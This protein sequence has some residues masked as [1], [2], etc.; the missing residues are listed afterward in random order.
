MSLT[1]SQLSSNRANAAFRLLILIAILS[2]IAAQPAQASKKTA[3]G[4]SLSFDLTSAAAAPNGGFWVQLDDRGGPLS[5]TYAIDGAPK[6][7]SIPVGGN[8][9]AIPGQEGYWVVSGSGQ[10][11]A[12]GSAPQLCGGQLSSCSGFQPG[13]RIITGAAANPD[14]QGLWAVDDHGNVWTA[15]TSQSYGDVSCSVACFIYPSSIVATPSGAG[16]Y[17]VKSDGSVLN[18]GDAVN[19]GSSNGERPGQTHDATGIALSMSRAGNVDGYWVVADC[20]IIK[21]YGHAAHLGD[22]GGCPNV[23]PIDVTSIAALPNGRS[24]VWLYANRRIEFSRTVPTV[25]ISSKY[26]ALV[27]AA[28]FATSG[29][30]LLMESP[31]GNLSQQ[32][33]LWPA[34]NLGTTVQLVNLNGS[35]DLCADIPN[36]DINQTVI[37]FPCSTRGAFNQL[38]KIVPGIQGTS[39][40]ESVSHPDHY[41]GMVSPPLIGAQLK[42]KG[43]TVEETFS[44]WNLQ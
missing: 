2:L 24:Y 43:R 29:S 31:N 10:I 20:G 40:I 34:D 16:Y 26:N 27:I 39:R 21:V 37:E 32:W 15:G 25:T 9:A 35:G 7:P 30:Q 6:F 8:I 36:N 17:I 12:R 19:Y 22:T 42:V 11:F 38:W 4:D 18:F 1:G 41:L 44:F 28:P 23:V 5:G 13:N 33:D 3:G 14:G